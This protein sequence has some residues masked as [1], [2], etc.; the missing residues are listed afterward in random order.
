MGTPVRRSTKKKTTG[1]L[2]GIT[3]APDQA[4]VEKSLLDQLWKQGADIEAFRDLVCDYIKL[5]QIKDKLQRD[6]ALRGVAYLE[7]PA[8]RPDADPIWKQNPSVKD[9]VMINKQMLSV[10]AQLY[11][12]PK[13]VSTEDGDDL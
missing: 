13:T 5:W 9:L 3:A 7:A 8:N 1:E 6:I 4:A 12:N 10:L 2:Y 11:L